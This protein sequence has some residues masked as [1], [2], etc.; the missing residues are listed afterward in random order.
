MFEEK[1]PEKRQLRC[2]RCKE[3]YSFFVGLP[4]KACPDCLQKRESQIEHLRT[5]IRGNPGITAM[6]LQLQ[7]GV[8][9]DFI[10]KMLEDGGVE[11]KK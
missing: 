1:K 7:T 9:F 5:L 6:E 3:F 4:K 10:H 8:P 11:L 2:P